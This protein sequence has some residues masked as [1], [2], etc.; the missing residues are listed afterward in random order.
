MVSSHN[1]LCF[2]N[3]RTGDIGRRKA[4]VVARGFEQEAQLDYFDTFASVLRYA[5]LRVILSKVAA[6]DLEADHI[7]ID[8]AFANSELK[9]EVYMEIPQ[10]FELAYPELKSIPANEL[11]LKV[12]THRLMNLPKGEG[13]MLAGV[14]YA[15][16]YLLLFLT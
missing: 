12:N 14:S 1:T 16:G 15:S 6:D 9:E 8:N 7:D 4:R 13:A 11:Y 2:I 3:T 10:Y 5:T